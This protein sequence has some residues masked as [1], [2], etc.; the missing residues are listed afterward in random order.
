[1]KLERIQFFPSSITA[2]INI[3]R[4]MSTL[5]K[6]QTGFQSSDFDPSCN[7]DEFWKRYDAGAFRQK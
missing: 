1:M 6:V 2:G 5:K 4:A 3:L 7:A